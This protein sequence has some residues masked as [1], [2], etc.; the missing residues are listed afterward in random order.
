[1]ETNRKCPSPSP[2][3]GFTLLEMAVAVVALTLLLGGAFTVLFH[4]EK[5]FAQQMQQFS[6]DQSGRKV[7]D[8]LAEELRAAHPASLLPLLIANSNFVSFQKVTGFSGGAVQ[9]GPRLT[10]GFQLAPGEVVNGLDENGNGVADD[11]FLTLT[12]TAGTPIRL[13]GNVQALR[14]TSI[15]GGM[16]YSADLAFKNEKGQV[17]QRTYTRQVAFRNPQ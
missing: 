12:P 16:S 17:T 8:R 13:C 14:F 10:L 3:D 2:R 9:L 7:M 4:G 15:A 6:F 1:M 11:G 5:L